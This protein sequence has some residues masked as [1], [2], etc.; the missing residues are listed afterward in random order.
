MQVLELKAKV[1]SGKENEL[2]QVIKDLIPQFI[3]RDE[4]ESRVHYDMEKG[5]LSIKLSDSDASRKLDEILES[6]N[7][8]LFLASVKVLCEEYDLLYPNRKNKN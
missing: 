5:E 1:K 3:S 4:I 6:K 7:F 2:D 8:S